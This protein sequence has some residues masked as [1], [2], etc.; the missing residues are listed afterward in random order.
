ML[1]AEACAAL[2]DRDAPGTATDAARA[3]FARLGA[4]EVA[5]PDPSGSLSPR[6]C[7]VLRLVAIGVTNRVIAQVLVLSEK[8]VARHVS[9]ILTKLGLASRAAATA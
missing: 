4:A 8:T 1:L 3:A 7:E 9:N 2:G 6:E 5:R